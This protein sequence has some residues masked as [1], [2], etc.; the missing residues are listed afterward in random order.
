LV[1]TN[2]TAGSTNIGFRSAIPDGANRWNIWNDGTAPNYFAGNVGIGASRTTPATALDVNGVI[3]VAAGSAAAPAICAS[4]D[5]NTGLA[6]PAADTAIISTAGVERV[7]VASDGLSTFSVPSTAAIPTDVTGMLSG[8]KLIVSATSDSATHS[9]IAFRTRTTGSSVA[10]VGLGYASSFDD[11]FL[12][13]RIRNGSGTNREVMRMKATGSVRFVPLA[14][15]PAS[16][17][18]AGDVYYNSST[19]K[20]RV[21]DGTNWVDLH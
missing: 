21:Y 14:A 12:F 16:G 17:N 19:N 18:E 1:P 4:G 7:R 2:F 10:N 9:A 6:F 20:L 8:P 11:G 15:D 3:T 5:A 13:F